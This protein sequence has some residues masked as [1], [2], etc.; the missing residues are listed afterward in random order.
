MATYSQKDIAIIAECGLRMAE[1]LRDVAKR[2]VPGATTA[3]LDQCAEKAIRDAGG[4]PS[5][6]HYR[7]AVGLTPFPSSLCISINNEVVHGPAYP[8]RSLKNGDI[9]G[10]DIGMR[11]PAKSGF[12]T[13]TAVTVVVG[14]GAPEALR[15][16]NVT[17]EALARGVA[18]VSAGCKV[19]TI[20]KAVETYVKEQGFSVVREFVGHG[21]GQHVHEAPEVPNFASR[22][23]EGNVVLPVGSVIAIEPMVNAGR[24][25]IDILEDGWT[26]V[27]LD[28]SLSAH[29]EQTIVVTKDG[30]K[31]LT[32][33]L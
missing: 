19:R 8:V 27:T 15:L 17:K 18:A 9:V 13:D 14:D 31:I 6:L 30:P 26:V 33:F 21:V 1:I 32:P 5:F 11:Y 3:E 20:G 2:A 23:E 7:G 25:E 16:V 4:V 28:G 29:F 22:G 24:S 12:C 10:L